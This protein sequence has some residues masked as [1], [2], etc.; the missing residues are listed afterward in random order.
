MP[1]PRLLTIDLDGTLVCRDGTVH[2]DDLAAIAAV[3]ELG[4]QV[5]IVT[6]RLYSGARPIAEQLGLKGIV[7]C[8]DGAELVDPLSHRVIRHRRIRDKAAAWMHQVIR[9]RELATFVMAADRIAYDSKGDPHARY[10]SNWTKAMER[11]PAVLELP[12]WTDE[13][14]ISALVAVGK[15]DQVGAAASGLNAH[16]GLHAVTFPVSTAPGAEDKPWL[17]S[18]RGVLVRAEGVNKGQA[19]RDLAAQHGMTLEDVVAVGDWINDIPMLEA[20][21]RSFVM[22]GAEPEV[23]EAANEELDARGWE[24]RGV[25]EAV[26]KVWGIT[27]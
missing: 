15:V 12:A 24:G 27:P 20:A 22:G 14:G 6:G 1:T 11:V 8:A 3:Q 9:S 26:R 2:P 10:M 23:R 16:E 4:V 7:I 5:S 19:V 21:G 25:A 18:Y 13:H 17:E